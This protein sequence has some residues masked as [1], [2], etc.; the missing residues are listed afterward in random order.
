MLGQKIYI[1]FLNKNKNFSKDKKY[2]E[3]VNDALKW[4]QKN[5]EK[6]SLDMLK[7]EAYNDK[8]VFE[9]KRYFDAN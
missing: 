8:T 2:F 1:E 7:N 3:T 9:G 5:L 6:F 4:A